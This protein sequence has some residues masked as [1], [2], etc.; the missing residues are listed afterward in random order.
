[1]AGI[2]G[3]KPR[4]WR[5]LRLGAVGAVATIIRARPRAS[6]VRW[7]RTCRPDPEIYRVPLGPALSRRPKRSIC[8]LVM[9]GPPSV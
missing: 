1:M 2:V 9:P 3:W 5:S 8:G 7:L 6:G 4:V